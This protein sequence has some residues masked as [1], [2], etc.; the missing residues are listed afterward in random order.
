MKS[1]NESNRSRRE[2]G[3]GLIGLSTVNPPLNQQQT[4]AFAA[5]SHLL[6]EDLHKVTWEHEESAKTAL[7]AAPSQWKL[8]LAV[9]DWAAALADVCRSY[10]GKCAE[11]HAGCGKQDPAT[12][13]VGTIVLALSSHLGLPADG[14]LLSHDWPE[15]NA[16]RRFVLWVS[17]APIKLIDGESLTTPTLPR[18]E[19]KSSL[20]RRLAGLNP[21]PPQGQHLAFLSVE[22]TE[23]MLR[24]LEESFRDTLLNK[25]G[26]SYSEAVVKLATEGVQHTLVPKLKSPGKDKLGAKKQD[27]SDYIDGARLTEKQQECFSLRMEYG[28][29][30]AEVAR[31]Q[32]ITRKTVDEHITAASNKINQKM[33]NDKHARTKAKAGSL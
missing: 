15:P 20:G 26:T 5:L 32:G 9:K 24:G 10:A 29:P 7:V 31:R 28:L 2:P 6:Q 17:G 27:L 14:T 30:V 25:L 33:A 4:D 22:E 11:M 18:W 1:R 3:E 12:S 23:Q 8:M 21:H 16:L 19:P 13:A